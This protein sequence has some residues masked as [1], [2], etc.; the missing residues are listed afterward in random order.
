[1]GYAVGYVQTVSIDPMTSSNCL[2]HLLIQTCH[3]IP[4][5]GSGAIPREWFM[6]PISSS[7]GQTWWSI[8]AYITRKQWFLCHVTPKSCSA[9]LLLY[10]KCVTAYIIHPKLIENVELYNLQT[11]AGVSMV[12]QTKVLWRHTLQIATIVNATATGAP[13]HDNTTCIRYRHQHSLS[14]GI[15][16]CW[17]LPCEIFFPDENPPGLRHLSHCCA[18]HCHCGALRHCATLLCVV[19]VVCERTM[20]QS[21]HMSNI[22]K[23]GD[24]W[25]AYTNN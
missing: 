9:S 4:K 10:I 15:D 7:I 11:I 5:F 23:S 21:V 13:E 25:H 19:V 6:H 16:F 17:A 3:L 8:I 24:W 18:L 2:N 12:I 22:N 14:G 1:M 20:S